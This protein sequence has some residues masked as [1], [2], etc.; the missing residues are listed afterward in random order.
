MEREISSINKSGLSQY[1]PTAGK[2]SNKVV[3]KT[4]HIYTRATQENTQAGQTKL[5]KSRVT[6]LSSRKNVNSTKIK[7]GKLGTNIEAE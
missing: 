6:N 3:I 7:L 4:I 5:K 2:T 1:T